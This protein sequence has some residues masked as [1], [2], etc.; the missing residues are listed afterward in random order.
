MENSRKCQI[1][2]IF[3]IA[4]IHKIDLEALFYR[5][6]K[7]PT[8]K[9]LDLWLRIQFVKKNFSQGIRDFTEAI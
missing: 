7:I 1:L 2:A 6:S 5:I 8:V 4:E 3:V 9:N